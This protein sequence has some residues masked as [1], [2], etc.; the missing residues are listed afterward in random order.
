MAE[1]FPLDFSSLRKGMIL[2]PEHH[3]FKLLKPV[4]N[5]PIGQVWHAQDL[6]TA[7]KDK[8]PDKV[9]LEIVNPLL[10]KGKSLDLFKTQVTQSKQMDMQHIAKTYGYF[11]SREGWLFVAMEPINTRSLA[12]ILLED[13]YQQLTVEKS[14]IILSQIAKALDYAH[15]KKISHGDLTPWN[16]IITPKS[17]AKLVNFAFRQPL[18][19]QIQQQGMRILNT[20]YHAPEAFDHL[21]LSNSADIFSFACLV[22]QLFSGHPPFNPEQPLED[23]DS[24]DLEP[25]KQMSH[26]QWEHLKPA[27]SDN[28]GDRPATASKLLQDLFPPNKSVEES[29]KESN[30]TAAIS[31]T[32]KTL[33]K[34]VKIPT[35]GSF[36]FP[37]LSTIAITFA[38][39]LAAGYFIA[40]YLANSKHQQLIAQVS[41]IQTLLAESPSTANKVAL[42]RLFTELK[43]SGNDPQLVAALD[44]QLNNYKLRL[45]KQQEQRTRPK[46]VIVTDNSTPA[47]KP[48]ANTTEANNG[49]V[50]G[51]VFKDEIIKNVY[52]PNMVVIPSGAYTMGDRNRRGDDNELPAHKVTIRHPF[53][54]S[55]HEVTFSDYDLFALDT[56]RQLP[57][58]EG[59][60]RG[61]RPVIN[62][63]WNDANAYADWLRRKTGLAYRL[64]TEAEW[65]YAA[66]AKT[67]SAFW[68][69]NDKGLNKAACDDCGSP[70]DGNQSAPTGS[71]KAN[72]FGLYDMN[73]NV[74]EWVSDCYNENYREAPADGSSWN[75]GQCN[76][77]VMRGGSWYDISRLIRSASRYRHPPNSSRNSWGFRL[78]LDLE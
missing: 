73:G 51:S 29:T 8:D 33:D 76:Y 9:A 57:D 56:G 39:G 61:T 48:S 34:T 58:D 17:G 18:L 59:W 31:P 54:L 65:E 69:G 78:A 67:A 62:I 11:M 63:S 43:A 12:R 75:V 72:P 16:V 53:A 13:G 50:A 44:S 46:S 55:Q 20:E 27:L 30:S 45:T 36:S 32:S 21:P 40:S 25:P 1:A 10:L 3:Q 7:E 60:G 37:K 68:W 41:Q 77:R 38:V 47:T 2:G 28:P 22:Y 71:F 70:F 15:K 4:S 26:E 35:T 52:G 19:Q 66:R 14:R 42:S 49:F 64:P 23:R 24:E 6:S 5:S 74:Y